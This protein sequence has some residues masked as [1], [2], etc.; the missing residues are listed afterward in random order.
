MS[1]FMVCICLC[2]VGCSE[3]PQQ[4]AGLGRVINSSRLCWHVAVT[5]NGVTRTASDRATGTTN[6][7]AIGSFGTANDGAIGAFG[8]ASD[9]AI[10]AF[11]EASDGAIGAFG[12]AN[13][14]T[15]RRMRVENAT[16]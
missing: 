15:G 16:V 5:P 7:G 14:W 12:A 10:G 8:T 1:C 3:S 11:G 4:R 2:L 9:G 6:D 13:G